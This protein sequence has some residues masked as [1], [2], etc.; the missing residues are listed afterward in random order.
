MKKRDKY[1]FKVL[2][3]NGLGFYRWFSGNTVKITDNKEGKLPFEMNM[4]YVAQNNLRFH[5]ALNYCRYKTTEKSNKDLTFILLT[6][7]D[8]K[9]RKNPIKKFF[10]KIFK[11]LWQH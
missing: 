4:I 7:E 11:K 3:K 1:G 8:W 5:V 9:N 2:D 10:K 6:E